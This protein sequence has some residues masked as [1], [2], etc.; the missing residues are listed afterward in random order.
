MKLTI[1]IVLDITHPCLWFHIYPHYFGLP[2]DVDHGDL[3]KRFKLLRQKFL[4]VEMINK[5]NIDWSYFA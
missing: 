4:V 3:I 2:L 1:T 5:H